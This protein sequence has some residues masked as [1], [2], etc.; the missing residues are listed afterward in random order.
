[1]K[2]SFR[3]IFLVILIGFSTAA[4]AKKPS[5][6]VCKSLNEKIKQYERLQEGGGSTTQIAYWERNIKIL[7]V[8][9][10][11]E[12]CGQLERQLR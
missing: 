7:R 5:L 3:F 11:K 9:F 8:R 6:A 12:D 2:K 10:A 4:L 1:M